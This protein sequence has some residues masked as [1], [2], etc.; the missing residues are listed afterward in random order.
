MYPALDGTYGT[1]DDCS[2]FFVGEASGC[3]EHKCFPLFGR[4][5]IES[6]AKV[7]H[8]HM[9]VLGRM[10]GQ[11]ID[12]LTIRIFVYVTPVA[13]FREERVALN[14]EQPRPQKRAF[15]EAVEVLP[16]FSSVSCARSSA[17]SESPVREKA[18]ARRLGINASKALR[19][20][21]DWE[22]GVRCSGWDICHLGTR[23]TS[24]I[25]AG[26]RS[27]FAA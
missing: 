26:N 24:S 25:R 20:V 22:F 4:H 5:G 2:R 3:D 13:T 10:D 8:I 12:F 21:G 1:S 23:T 17:R 18:K 11:C 14:G 6:A 15:P 16:R 19:C 7:L 27:P 9:A